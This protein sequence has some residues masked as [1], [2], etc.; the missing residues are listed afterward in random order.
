M[1]TVNGKLRPEVLQDLANKTDF[2]E[3]ELREKYKGFLADNPKGSLSKEQ[4]KTLYG[5]LFPKGDAAEFSEY[6]FR[7]F[8]TN[9]NGSIDF[10]EFILALSITSQGNNTEKLEWAF[11]LYDI[12]GN[13]SISR[14]EVLTIVTALYRMVED[15]GHETAAA[16]TEKIFS[17]LD[18]D[19]N[20][21]I[22]LTEFVQGSQKNPLVMSLLD[23]SK[24]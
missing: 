10:R 7:T 5:S 16:T 24:Q 8:D 14:D 21:I 17:W 15:R 22:S 12:N 13:G 2:T 1:G 18:R 3:K 20:G 9:H 23:F 4:F 11:G 19:H 6:V